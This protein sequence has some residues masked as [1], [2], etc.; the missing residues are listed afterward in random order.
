M[1]NLLINSEDAV[2][3]LNAQRASEQLGGSHRSAAESVGKLGSRKP[4][5]KT[6]YQNEPE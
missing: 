1:E 5:K 4:I 3:P 6:S 2:Q